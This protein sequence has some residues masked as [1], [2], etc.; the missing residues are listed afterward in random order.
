MKKSISL[1]Y[2]GWGAFLSGA[3][4][5]AGIYLGAMVPLGFYALIIPT[6]L[7]TLRWRWPGGRIAVG[8]SMLC[9]LPAVI[10]DVRLWPDALF[11]SVLLAG[12]AWMARGEYRRRFL[13]GEIS[14]AAPTA[15]SSEFT[16]EF[17]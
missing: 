4:A 10:A 6:I 7:A 17:T 5:L 11:A 12:A 16:D 9:I 14:A 3:L 1:Q 8:V 13:T 15:A 2:L